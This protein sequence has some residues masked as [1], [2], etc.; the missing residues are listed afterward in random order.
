MLI[1]FLGVKDGQLF[2]IL[3]CLDLLLLLFKDWI[4]VPGAEASSFESD[5]LLTFCLLQL[6]PLCQLILGFL[7]VLLEDCSVLEW[8][9]LLHELFLALTLIIVEHL[10]FISI[11]LLSEH[12]WLWLRLSVLDNRNDSSRQC[13]AGF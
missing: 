13:R 12:F 4:V 1:L 3:K 11:S 7:E 10:D 9:K 5:C 6:L 8:P 2:L